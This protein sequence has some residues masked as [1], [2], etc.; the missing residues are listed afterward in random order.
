MTDPST[1][2]NASEALDAAERLQRAGKFDAAESLYRRAIALEPENGEALFL[3]GA[4]RREGGDLDGAAVLLERATQANPDTAPYW[5]ELTRIRHDLAQWDDCVTTAERTLAIEE[6]STEAALM[7]A[8]A[9]FARQ[10]HEA[11]TGFIQRVA[12]RLPDDAGVHLFHT[13]C[14]MAG[15][16]YGDAYAPAR[17][18]ATLAPDSADAQYLLGACLK[19]IGR[20]EAA[21]SALQHCLNIV[22]NHYEALN[23]LADI[24]IA[25]GDTQAALTCLRQSHAVQ[26]YN[27][28]AISGLCFYTAFDPNS[29][30]T[31]L[32]ELN[33]DWSQRLSAEAGTDLHPQR[34]IIATD[35]RIRIAY[36]AYDL[37]DHVTSWFLEPVL[38][39]HD[40]ERFHVT[41]YYGN[42]NSDAI[43]ERLRGYTDAWQSVANDSIEET[44]ER[45]RDD[46]IDI[47]VLASFFRGKDK[48][49]L[50]YRSAP[51]QVG[52]H[53]R[54]ASTGLETADYIITEHVSDPVGQ[55]EKFYTEALVRLTN[56]NVYLPPPDAP[57]PLPPPCLANGYVTFGSFNNLAKIG[58]NVIAT[59][60]NI[61]N[62]IPNARLL[63]RSSVHF[64]DPTTRDYFQHRFQLNGIDAGRLEFQGLKKLRKDHLAGM[65]EVD[66]T[67]DPFPCNGGT[68]SCEALWMGLP[69]V[70]METDSYMGRQGSSYL[71]K[72]DLNDLVA[73][74]EMDYVDAAVRL[75][76]DWERIAVLRKT[77]RPKVESA[78]FDYDQHVL[79]LETAYRHM[80]DR[81]RSGKAPAA[82]DVRNNAAT[83]TGK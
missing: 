46:G 33:R 22:P 21:E 51:L 9:Y 23:D 68:T 5:L 57:A 45:I 20:N 83:E 37:L 10:E 6:E 26:P 62:E 67:L 15:K 27:L 34:R 75:A 42:E 43:T 14:L 8:V 52:Y 25:R 58:D 19:R 24:F 59:W 80:M 28:D 82:F 44:A 66:I 31:A 48:R 63:L 74:T 13:R 54:V 29:D 47:L 12:A 38:S 7:C 32:Y 70:T 60:S 50:A 55:V 79:E 69:L 78:I 11:A 35:S 53:N 73:K 17:R 41:G 2:D 72:L 40:H 3:L 71:A 61:L 64:D 56:H 77:L 16:R 39:R 30:T 81:H 65:R 1:Y 36:L 49:V 18:A 76:E 4:R